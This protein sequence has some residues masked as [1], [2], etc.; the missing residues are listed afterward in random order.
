MVKFSIN[1]SIL[2]SELDIPFILQ[3]TWAISQDF[4]NFTKMITFFLQR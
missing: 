2:G 3:N 1:L 4:E